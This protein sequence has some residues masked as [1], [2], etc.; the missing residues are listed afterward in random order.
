MDNCYTVYAH[1]NKVN[2]KMYIGLTKQKP[3]RR[4]NNGYGYVHTPF[5]YNAIIKYGWDNFEHI[6]LEE[7]LLKKEAAV[8]ESE[9]INLYQTNIKELG[10]NLTSGG[11][12]KFNNP[13]HSLAIRRTNSIEERRKMYLNEGRTFKVDNKNGRSKPIY[14]YDGSTGE[15]IDELSS[16]IEAELKY[17]IL[18]TIIGSVCLKRYKKANGYIFR[19]QQDISENNKYRLPQ[20][21]LEYANSNDCYVAVCQYN[22]F[23]KKVN[24]YDNLRE[25][26]RSL[27]LRPAR[28]QQ[29]LIRQIYYTAN[30]IWLPY[31]EYKDIEQ[32]DKSFV[33]SLYL[34]IQ[35]DL[36]IIKYS[37]EGE[38]IAEY[39]TYKEAVASLE[40]KH[41]KASA[42]SQCLHGTVKSAYG[43]V[44]KR[45]DLNDMV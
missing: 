15:L 45:K 20:D 6:I 35:R 28:I 11:F 34:T 1:V 7:N 42:V 2:D 3:E 44:W 23:G 41:G 18:N 26:A 13:P 25:A 33:D 17:G 22:L 31:E 9:L 21:E 43:F 14:M 12:H 10:Y 30:F 24:T 27:G 32:L 36:P 29:C 16:T 37:L 5:F 38:F 8:L 40:G 19:Y 4:W 39:I